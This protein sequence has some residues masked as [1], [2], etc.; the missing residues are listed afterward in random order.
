MPERR[1][2]DSI[3]EVSIKFKLTFI[4]SQQ[5]YYFARSWLP[6]LKMITSKI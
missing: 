6:P 2:T 3:G 1:M 4:G 5:K